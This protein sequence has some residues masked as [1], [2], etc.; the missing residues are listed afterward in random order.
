MDCLAY[1]GFD[2]GMKP[3]GFWAGLTCGASTTLIGSILINC[4]K[5]WHY[6]PFGSGWLVGGKSIGVNLDLVFCGSG[7]GSI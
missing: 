2:S 3:V 7:V 5:V 4:K 6:L 1:I